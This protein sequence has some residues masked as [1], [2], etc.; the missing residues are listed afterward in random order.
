MKKLYDSLFVFSVITS[1]I[2]FA[3]LFNGWF[4]FE[5]KLILILSLF[6]LFILNITC[7]VNTVKRIIVLNSIALFINNLVFHVINIRFTIIDSDSATLTP[8]LYGLINFLIQ[9]ILF[10]FLNYLKNKKRYIT[11]CFILIPCIYL[12]FQIYLEFN[13]IDPIGHRS[14]SKIINKKIEF[15]YGC[16]LDRYRHSDVTFK[17][18]MIIRNEKNLELETDL[19]S[20]YPKRYK[21]TILNGKELL[22]DEAV[23][24]VFFKCLDKLLYYKIKV[25]EREFIIDKDTLDFSLKYLEDFNMKLVISIQNNNEEKFKELLKKKGYFKIN[26]KV[27]ENALKLKAYKFLKILAL[28]KHEEFYNYDFIRRSRSTSETMHFYLNL[29]IDIPEEYLEKYYFNIAGFENVKEEPFLILKKRGLDIFEKA[30]IDTR[31]VKYA[32]SYGKGKFK[33]NL[34]KLCEKGCD[35]NSYTYH[36]YISERLDKEMYEIVK[37]YNY[38]IN[39]QDKHNSRT[40]LMRYAIY[41]PWKARRFLELGADKNIK[42]KNGKTAYDIYIKTCDRFKYSFEKDD[43]IKRGKYLK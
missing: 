26:N 38:D 20:I 16:E 21:G 35:L 12:G 3:L 40:K 42:D 24:P 19:L 30:K 14:F 9:L 43:C 1:F 10:K 36:E 29:A 18:V 8:L 28:E 17:E 13:P 41:D 2:V 27:I 34:K 15:N 7:S 4:D 32:L 31:Y 5:L 37:E 11:I 25:S 33:E 22:I 23:K 6:N 39:L